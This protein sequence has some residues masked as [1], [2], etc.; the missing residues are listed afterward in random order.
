MTFA[1][2]F[3][4]ETDIFSGIA[5]IATAIIAVIAYGSYRYERWDRHRRLLTLLKNQILKYPQSVD[6]QAVTIILAVMEL[7]ISE[8]QVMEAAFGDEN[9]V[10]NGLGI[11]MTFRYAPKK[12]N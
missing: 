3:K 12:S 8:A 1:M 6:F 5:S 9:I 11:H 7:R 2:T 10:V 4:D